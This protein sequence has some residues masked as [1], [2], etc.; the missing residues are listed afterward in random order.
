MGMIPTLPMAPLKALMT[1]PWGGH[2]E[3]HG[4]CIY[5]LFCFSYRGI[6]MPA[7]LSKANRRYKRQVDSSQRAYYILLSYIIIYI[8]YDIQADVYVVWAR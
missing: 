3:Y 7:S 6:C 5:I 1:P 8:V 4:M 2:G